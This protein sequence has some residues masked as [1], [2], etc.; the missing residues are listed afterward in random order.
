MVDL[1][2]VVHARFL[3]GMANQ[4]VCIVY[5]VRILIQKEAPS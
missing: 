5:F 1:K 3:S 2:I 4:A